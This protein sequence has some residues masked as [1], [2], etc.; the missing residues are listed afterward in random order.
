MTGVRLQPKNHNTSF[1]GSMIGRRFVALTAAVLLL[2]APGRIRADAA[3]TADQ[4]LSSGG[5]LAQERIAQLRSVSLQSGGCFNEPDCGET[6]VVA[7]SLQSET[8]IAVDSTGQ[9]LVIGFNDFRGFATNPATVPLSIS[10]FMYSDDGGKTFVDGGRLPSPGT[11][12]ISGQLFP[13]I[14]GDPDV[15]YVGG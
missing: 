9:H 13:Q 15:K 3:S 7:T 2:L 6:P 5:Q 11:D 10:G 4:R 12:V 14:F 8:T 1:G